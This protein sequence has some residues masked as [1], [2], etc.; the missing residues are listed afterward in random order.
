MLVGAVLAAVFAASVGAGYSMTDTELSNAQ[1]IVHHGDGVVQVNTET[2]RV[3]AE[4]RA[5]A[6]GGQQLELVRLADGRTASVN[7]A[8]GQVL[9]LNED[10]G[11][12]GAPIN[13]SSAGV[14]RP[15]EVP[16]VVAA[17]SAAYLLRP[18][19]DVVELID[20]DGTPQTPV[21]VPRATPTAVGDGG[22]G[23][24]VLTEDGKAVHVV[25]G[26]V[27]R[28]V[29]A[30]EPIEHLTLADGRPIGITR[31]G[32]ALDVAATPLKS[33]SR[34][35]VPHGDTVS[36]PSAKGAGR[37]LLVLDRRGKLVSVDPRTGQRREFDLPKGVDHNLGAPVVLEDRVYVPDY[38]EH[39]LRSFDLRTGS[40]TESITVPGKSEKFTVEVQD[41]RVVANDPVDR[42][43]VAVD[44]DGRR[45]VIDKGKAPGV[46]T[47]TENPEPVQ[48]SE[49]PRSS[50]PP[51]PS[52]TRPTSPASP[53]ATT[54]PTATVTPPQVPK[55]TVPVV[56]PGTDRQQ[57][58][59]LVEAAALRCQ[60]V[61]I[62]PG[63]A[64]GTVRDT[65][66]RGGTEAPEGSTV[67][68]HVYGDN[69]RVP[70][71]VGMLVTP[72]CDSVNAAAAPPGGDVCDEQA[73]PTAGA[74]WAALGVVAEQSPKGG[75]FV[76]AG[77][78]VAVRHWGFVAM[79]DLRGGVHAGDAAC[80]AIIAESNDQVQCR[81]EQGNEGPA[82]GTVE[83]ST[84]APGAQVRI[85]DAVVLTV[86]R[87]A[88]PL[89]PVPD[90]RNMTKEQA[91]QTLA[92]GGW[93]C[94]LRPDGVHP[95]AVVSDQ[96]PA[97]GTLQ[98]G[99]VVIVHY[100]PYQAVPLW[101][102]QHD[103]GSPVYILRFEGTVQERY[104]AEKFLGYAYPVGAIPDGGTASLIRD[105]MCNASVRACGG[106]D[107]NHYSTLD[108]STEKPDWRLESG[109]GLVLKPVNGQCRT[110]QRMIAR[111]R[112]PVGNQERYTVDFLDAPPAGFDYHEP[113]GCVW[114]AL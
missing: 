62:G 103:N 108:T 8:T 109:V 39:E 55:R 26:Q 76:T 106:L 9:L 112:I 44:P 98:R 45:T 81:I 6:T 3:E 69:V 113:L 102:Y 63:G 65:N 87:Q 94:E 101:R 99:G 86:Y 89:P 74:N 18:G 25:G 84:P 83:S 10:L 36:V 68:V 78:R 21:S 31:S 17:T 75:E 52:T 60:V 30:P 46:K 49:P 80:S 91:C 23:I 59:T 22:A 92:E 28:T 12:Q 50:T 27:E 48:P 54:S 96:Q 57:A 43:T 77:T 41:K 38:A 107:P 19:E 47:D 32:E 7:H 64:T 15:D 4:A 71:V 111:F 93:T 67:T 11:K 1:A 33:I 114:R 61:E 56:P 66:P 110:D 53:T 14:P 104:H 13:Q 85:G 100:S 73:M 40:R 95:R 2:E 97:P 105:F 79:P 37:Y 20:P 5:L 90:V 58:C 34:E 16:V 72:A 29:P 35:P 88:A 24:W 42:R 51:P 82:P 70:D